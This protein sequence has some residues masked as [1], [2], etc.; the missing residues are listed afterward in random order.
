M[1]QAGDTQQLASNKTN[2]LLSA[3]APFLLST[4]IFGAAFGYHQYKDITQDHPGQYLNYSESDAIKSAWITGVQF[5]LLTGVPVGALSGTAYACFM[6][7]R[8]GKNK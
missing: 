2:L 3:I 4:V 8:R 7:V 1:S 6:F 5:G